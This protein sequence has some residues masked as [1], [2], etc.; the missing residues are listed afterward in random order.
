[1][2]L[3]VCVCVFYDTNAPFKELIEHVEQGMKY[4]DKARGCPVHTGAGC[5]K[6]LP[7]YLYH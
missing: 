6:Y 7:A 2:F 1:M 3:F 5:P 4:V